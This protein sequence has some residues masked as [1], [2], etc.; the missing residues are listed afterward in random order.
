MRKV[1]DLLREERESKNLTLADIEEATKIKKEFIVAIEEGKFHRLPSES[2]A[3]GFVKNYAKFLGV[4]ESS[5]MPLFRREYKSRHPFHIVPE[6]RK[7]QHKF[8]R[9]FFLSAKTLLVVFVIFIVGIYVF[10]QYST[11]VFPPK[12]E[13]VTPQN[14]QAFSGNVVE[15]KGK[16]D[17]YATVSV[18]GDETYVTLQGTFKKAV[19]TFSG[20]NK[21]E[22]ITKNRF[23]KE[24]RKVIN[25][26]VE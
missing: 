1:S 3:Q 16:T 6:F 8:N 12:L 4:P 11:L 2:Y 14:G 13:I 26:R 24:S 18:N 5:A 23:G 15:V 20:E 10:F 25:V 21:I 9:T 7:S 19:Y 17:P 22:V